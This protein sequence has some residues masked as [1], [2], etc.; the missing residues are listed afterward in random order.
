MTIEKK[1]SV[2]CSLLPVVTPSIVMLMVLFGQA[3][4][5]RAARARRTVSTPGSIAAK[6]SALREPSGSFVDL[7]DADRR[8]HR[9]RL[10]LDQLGAGPDFDRLGQRADF[11]HRLHAGAVVPVTTRTSLTTA[12]LKPWSV[13][14]TV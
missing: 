2:D 3:A 13:T 1:P 7:L 9:G 11:E 6:Y 10:R 5:C 8:G 14:V 12:V 4:E